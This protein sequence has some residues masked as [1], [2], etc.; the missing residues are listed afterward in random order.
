MSQI[1]ERSAKLEAQAVELKTAL[2]KRQAEFENYRNRT[3][4]ERNETYQG[5]IGNLASQLLPVL[6]NLNRALDI[7][8]DFEEERHKDFQNFFNGIVLVNQQ[9]NEVLAEMGVQP[10][11]SVGEPF[12]PYFH[13][14]VATE[15]TAEFPSN[16][17]TEQ[18][19]RGYRLGDRLIRP[20]MVKVAIPK[21]QT[22]ED[23]S[24]EAE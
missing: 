5:Q 22:P 1:K 20:A 7:A 4:R 14:A 12:D 9:L 16:T 15:E 21:N 8:S 2:K 10:V 24:P 11:P 6:D 17:I 19:L 23:A 13:D 18:L 3:E